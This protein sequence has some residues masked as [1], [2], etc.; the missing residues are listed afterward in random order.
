M[1]YKTA[2]ALDNEIE[3]TVR[4]RSYASLVKY[5][6]I[7]KLLSEQCELPSDD[8][9]SMI[10]NFASLVSR[11]VNVSKNPDCSGLASNWVQIWE[12]VSKKD[13]LG[14]YDIF[15]ES[16]I[17]GTDEN[18]LTIWNDAIMSTEDVTPSETLAP[19][20]VVPDDIKKN[21]EKTA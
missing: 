20:E 3:L 6:G 1:N 8:N 13:Y 2:S 16:N 7:Q 15:L 11:T 14:A 5:S 19:P 12:C 17:I 18:L 10:T 4:N 21:T 9:D